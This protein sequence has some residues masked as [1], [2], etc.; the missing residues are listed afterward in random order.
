MMADRRRPARRASYLAS[1]E[2]LP[3]AE[4][5]RGEEP[6]RARRRQLRRAEGAAGRRAST[7]ATTARRSRRSICR[8]SSSTCS[9]TASGA[10]SARN[11]ASMPLDDDEHVHPVRAGR[12]RRRRRPDQLPRGD[13]GRDAG[14][15]PAG[16]ARRRPI[17]QCRLDD[18]AGS[19][20]VVALRGCVG[21][22]AAGAASGRSS[23]ARVDLPARLTDAEF[24]QLIED[25]SEPGRH[26]Q[27]RQPRL[28]RRPLSGRHSR[29]RQRASAR[30]RRTSASGPIRTSPTSRRSSRGSPSSPTSGAATCTCT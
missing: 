14:L 21:L 13:A 5:P 17:R 28:E 22:S 7:C 27:L 19:P 25:F 26:F 1:E 24:W 2:T 29:A 15:R 18:R 8:T 3:G 11:V 10:T 6:A 30:R 12:R 4:G 23:R 16:P 20:L 9:R